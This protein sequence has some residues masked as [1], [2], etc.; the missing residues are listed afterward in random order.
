MNDVA[1]RVHISTAGYR[2]KETSGLESTACC[3]PS[4]F[5]VR[6]APLDDVIKVQQ[7][8]LHRWITLEHRS[9]HHAAAGADITH[10]VDAAQ[11][12][13]LQ[14]GV[15][16]APVEGLHGGVE[17]GRIL[18]FLLQILEYGFA[19]RQVVPASPSPEILLEEWKSPRGARDHSARGAH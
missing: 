2:L 19:E 18:R 8:G 13:G 7:N 12:V 3:E 4:G 16:L 6:P 1:D 14:H 15:G 9:Y 17:N 5:H 10:H 11:R